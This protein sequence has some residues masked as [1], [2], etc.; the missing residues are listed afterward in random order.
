MIQE[1][2]FILKNLS[3]LSLFCYNKHMHEERR[4]RKSKNA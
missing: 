1:C 3:F 4:I 2:D